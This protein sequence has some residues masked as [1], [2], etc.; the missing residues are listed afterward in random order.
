[1]TSGIHISL[2]AE[3]IFEIGGF[4]ITNSL[5]TTWIVMVFLTIC[6]ILLTRNL[7]LI[8]KR[9]QV[10][11]EMIIGGIFGFFESVT[12]EKTKTFFPLIGTLFIFIIF[13]NWFGLIPGVGTIGINE[14]ENGEKV[15]V[16][17]FRA[18]SADINTT[19]AFAL[20]SVLS[21]QYYG[22]KT[23]KGEYIGRFLNFKD[24]IYFFV[25]ILEF[26]LEFAKIIS[27]TFRLFGNIFAGEVLLTI[28]AFLIPV[29]APIPFL[30]MEMFVGFIQALVF[31]MLTAVFLSLATAKTEH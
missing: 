28:I 11:T 2:K 24:P 6:S 27:F 18:G 21:I 7:S 5:L 8:P 15:F 1:M 12:K 10:F 14:V 30:G 29:I 16:P 4:P 3:K 25:G 26:V 19:L 31:S 13:L 23:L 20:I 17:I 22:L 9:A